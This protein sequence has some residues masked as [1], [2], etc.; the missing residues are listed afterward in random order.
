MK[1]EFYDSLRFQLMRE[2]WRTHAERFATQAKSAGKRSVGCTKRVLPIIHGLY[3]EASPERGTF[4]MLQQY[5]MVEISLVEVFK[6]EG[7]KSLSFRSVK[8]PK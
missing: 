6:R 8:R 5:E 1:I 2:S 3:G 4:F 7:K